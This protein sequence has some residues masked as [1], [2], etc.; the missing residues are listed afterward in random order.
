MSDD[1]KAKKETVKT[2]L[3]ENRVFEP[4]PE[5][6]EGALIKD[7][8]I[9]EEASGGRDAFWTKYANDLEW[10]KKWDKVLDWN[11]PF[12]KWFVRGKLNASYNC[13]DRHIK[14]GKGG[15]TAI[16]WEGE[17]G[18][19]R[20]F[21]Y[22]DVYKSVNK[23]ANAI[24]KLG[25]AKGDRVAIYMPMVPEAAFAMLACSR[26]GAIHTVVFGGFG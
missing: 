19:E 26:I 24:K 21:T 25:I 8:S 12:A 7:A 6:K 10:H 23:L 20:Q 22:D 9:Y 15:K 2:L 1:S 4:S 11:P 3:E 13:L 14:A 17:D 5:F 16:L 18:Q